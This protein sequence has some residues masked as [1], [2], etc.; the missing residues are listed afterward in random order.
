MT[1]SE[2]AGR[3]RLD[4]GDWGAGVGRIAILLEP[5]S[6]RGIL[7]PAGF[8]SDGASVPRVLWWF[9][10]PWGDV[11]TVAALV[12]DFAC[13]SLKAGAPVPGG[14]TRSGCD[15]LFRDALISTGVPAWRAWVCWSGVRAY[16]IVEGLAS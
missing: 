15:R 2:F 10:P 14:A 5:V 16:S 9:L 13:D 1:G 11:S 12:H 6:W 8:M 4:F 7:L 3:L